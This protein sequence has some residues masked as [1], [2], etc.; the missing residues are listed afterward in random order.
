MYLLD[1]NVISE[2][3]KARP[4][5]A[6]VAFLQGQPLSQLYLS[7]ITLG[8][9]EWGTEQVTDPARRAALRQWLTH[10]VLPDY[11]GRILPID[12][13]VM[14]TWARMVMASGLK[15][16]QLPCMD[17]LLAA[18]ALH[19]DLTLVTRNRSDFQAFGIHLLNPWE[20]T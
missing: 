16:K 13:Q 6:V 8:E 1:T 19:H 2:A 3:T 17:A 20:T 15:P 10:S 12:E 18:T 14:V 9:L 5:P 4:A 11:L 7:A